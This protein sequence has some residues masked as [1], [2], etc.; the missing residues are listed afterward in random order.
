MGA[1]V[2]CRTP[3]EPS[4]GTL[5][6]RYAHLAIAGGRTQAIFP[7]GGLTRD[8]KLRPPKL[9]LLSYIVSGFDPQ[10]RRDAVFVPVGLNYDRVLEDRVQVAALVATEGEKP[11]FKFSPAVLLGFIANSINLR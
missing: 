4:Q 3:S 5:L 11:R 7:E 2:V 9:G 6:A 10:G 8:G 1:C